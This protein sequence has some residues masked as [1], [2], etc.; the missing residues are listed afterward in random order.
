MG[1]RKKGNGKGTWKKGEGKWMKGKKGKKGK[2]RGR[3]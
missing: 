3:R 2:G 1:E